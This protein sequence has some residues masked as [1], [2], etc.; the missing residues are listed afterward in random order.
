[1]RKRLANMFDIGI[2]GSMLALNRNVLGAIAAV[3]IGACIRNTMSYVL[4]GKKWAARQAKRF[5][6]GY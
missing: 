3:G 1:M 5:D 2:G 4:D 6:E